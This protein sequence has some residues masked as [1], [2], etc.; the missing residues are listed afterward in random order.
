MM[1]ESSPLTHTS[2][3][4]NFSTESAGIRDK[5]NLCYSEWKR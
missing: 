2:T 1:T 4:L 3:L 5:K